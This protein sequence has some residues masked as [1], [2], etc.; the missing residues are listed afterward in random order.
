MTLQRSLMIS[1]RTKN[2]DFGI[3]KRN[4]NVLFRQMQARYDAL[5]G[6]NVPGGHRT[7][8]LPRRLHH[9]PMLEVRTMRPWTTLS[10]LV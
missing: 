7:T 5:I 4:H 9:V 1:V 8:L 6:C 2:M 3:I 10:M